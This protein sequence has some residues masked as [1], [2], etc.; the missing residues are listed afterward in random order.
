M[1]SLITAL[2]LTVPIAAA[3]AGFQATAEQGKAVLQQ[4]N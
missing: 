4:Q 1:R 3:A 2:I